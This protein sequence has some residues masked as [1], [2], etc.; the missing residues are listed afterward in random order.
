MATPNTINMD[1]KY[2]TLIDLYETKATLHNFK[3]GN[4]LLQN[5]TSI[6]FRANYSIFFQY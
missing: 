1:S 6:I 3:F 2:K 4:F 5:H